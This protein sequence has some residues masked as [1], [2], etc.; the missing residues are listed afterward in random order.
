MSTASLLLVSI[1]T[2]PT[3]RQRTWRQTRQTDKLAFWNGAIFMIT[4]DDLVWYK[5]NYVICKMSAMIFIWW[6]KYLLTED[7]RRQIQVFARDYKISVISPSAMILSIAMIRLKMTRNSLQIK[8][9][10]WYWITGL[11]MSG[12]LRAL[13]ICTSYQ[14]QM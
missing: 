12:H 7:P 6:K 5:H 9:T 8:D 13:Y 2:R 14:C 11:M 1:P 10:L 4:H 3:I